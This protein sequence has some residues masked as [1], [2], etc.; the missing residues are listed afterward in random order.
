MPTAKKTTPPVPQEAGTF[1]LKT[2]RAVPYVVQRSAQ[3]KRSY[4]FV[5]NGDGVVV[6]RAPKWVRVADLEDFG[7]R[8]YRFIEARLAELEKRTQK[9]AEKARVREDMEGKWCELPDD[10]YRKTARKMYPP[11]LAYWGAR[12]G[13]QVHG[14]RITSGKNVWG[15]CTSAG[16]IN[17]SWRLL[18]VP[19]H[20][21]EYVICHEVC[22]RVHMNHGVR[23]WRLVGK[24]L[25]N[26]EELRYEINKLGGGAE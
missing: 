7:G 22:H 3:R 17:L 21:R 16:N 26:Y 10:W 15:S 13:V 9:A 20:L 4:G 11:R 25:P 23:F 1:L 8:R 24:F 2:G 12:V 19:E 14:L 18:L 5:V 6:F